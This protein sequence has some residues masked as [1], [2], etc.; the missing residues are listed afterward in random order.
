MSFEN[1]KVFDEAI[2]AVAP[3]VK[4]ILLFIDNK[5]KDNTYEI[6]L[7]IGRPIMLITKDSSVYL[8]KNSSGIDKV[9]AVSRRTARDYL[10]KKE[11][12]KKKKKFF[13]KD[14]G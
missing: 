6:R 12:F 5:I 4:R 7:R 9:I 3:E 14:I 8:N 11:Y 2:W 13:K 1:K 10:K